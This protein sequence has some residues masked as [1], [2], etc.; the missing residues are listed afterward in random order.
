MSDSSED[1]AY[2]MSEQH[3]KAAL[4]NRERLVPI[5]DTILLRGRLRIAQRGR[6]GTTGNCTSTAQLWEWKEIL[7][8]F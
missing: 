6:F 5:V 2:H 8:L 4:E 3:R 1:V 7:A